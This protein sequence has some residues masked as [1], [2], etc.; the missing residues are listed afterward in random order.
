M[1]NRDCFLLPDRE[2][3]ICGPPCRLTKIFTN[4][5]DFTQLFRKNLRQITTEVCNQEVDT[6]KRFG[7]FAKCNFDMQ[8]KQRPA[9]A[10][11]A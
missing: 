8:A 6:A 5:S 3:R 4:F 9:V 10:H 1:K 2:R 11:R 7:K